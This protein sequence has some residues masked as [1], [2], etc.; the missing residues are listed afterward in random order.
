MARCGDKRIFCFIGSYG[1]RRKFLQAE[2]VAKPFLRTFAHHKGAVRKHDSVGSRFNSKDFTKCADSSAG[3]LQVF[4]RRLGGSGR[5]FNIPA[6][7]R[8][9]MAIRRDRG[10]GAKP[11]RINETDVRRWR[12]EY[13]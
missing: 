13:A 10:D 9:G 11:A 3:S 7:D 5:K 4:H 6:G 12:L 8:H 2:I 1:A